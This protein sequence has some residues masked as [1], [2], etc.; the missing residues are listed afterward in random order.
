MK[1][2]N[3][4]LLSILAALLACGCEST[5]SAG[6]ST[7]SPANVAEGRVVNAEDGFLELRMADGNSR[8]FMLPGDDTT[9]PSNINSHIGRKCLIQFKKSSYENAEGE[10]SQQLEITRFVWS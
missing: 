7:A 10:V 5:P 6:S 8:F 2:T 1:K 9:V 3:F 4:L